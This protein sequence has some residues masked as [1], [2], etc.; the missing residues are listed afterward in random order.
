MNRGGAH[1]LEDLV[2]RILA[3]RPR[4]HSPCWEAL[5]A[6]FA[7]LRADLEVHVFVEQDVVFPLAIEA[8]QVL[9]ERALREVAP[10]RDQR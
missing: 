2:T 6:D 4:G 7:A 10:R 1:S 5:E 9:L 3:A 8:E